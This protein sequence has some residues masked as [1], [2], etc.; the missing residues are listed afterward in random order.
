MKYIC[1]TPFKV[2]SEK[3]ESGFLP[4]LPIQLYPL[5]SLLYLFAVRNHSYEYGYLGDSQHRS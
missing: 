1:V 2:P 3:F 4:T 5:P